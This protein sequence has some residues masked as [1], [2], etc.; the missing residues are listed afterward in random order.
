MLGS[1]LR[2]GLEMEN[3]YTSILWY[4][5]GLI[6]GIYFLILAKLN[7]DVGERKMFLI[8]VLLGV[9]MISRAGYMLLT[10]FLT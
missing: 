7:L 6:V 1:E 4:S 5:S 8:D 10:M 9:T 2:D 3:E